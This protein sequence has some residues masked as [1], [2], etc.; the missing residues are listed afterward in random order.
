MLKTLY[1]SKL[2]DKTASL[3]VETTG[4]D[5]SLEYSSDIITVEGDTFIEMLD[6]KEY[7]L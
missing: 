6:V 4:V 5:A 7:L 2:G 3:I 1:A